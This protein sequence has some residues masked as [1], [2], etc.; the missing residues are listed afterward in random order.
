MTAL[1]QL[2]LALGKTVQGSDVADTFS[3][4]AVLQSAGIRVFTSA[5][6]DQVAPPI[7]CVVASSSYAEG[8]PEI[9]AARDRGITVISYAA[10]MGELFS[11]QKGIAVV[12]SHGKTTTTALLGHALIAAG[13]DPTVSV[14]FTIPQWNGNCRLGQSKW[15]V[16]EADEYQNKLRFFHPFG[17]VATNVDYDHVDFFPTRR[18]YQHVFHDFFA[19]IPPEGFFVYCAEDPFLTQVSLQ[20]KTRCYGYG[21]NQG[22]WQLRDSTTTGQ[23][24]SVV[25]NG[26]VVGQ[27]RLQIWGEK[28]LLNA[29][30]AFVAS[31]VLGADATAACRGLNEYRG[32]R[33]RMERVG[34]A[35]GALLLDDYAHHPAEIRVTL[36]AVRQHF[37][38]RRILALFQ[39]H[40]FS[41]TAAFLN[42]FAHALQSADAIA[43]LEIYPSAREPRG[44][45]SARPIVDQLIALGKAA[46]WTPTHAAAAAWLKK[47]ITAGDVVITLGAG[48]IW[49]L[50]QK[51]VTNV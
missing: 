48:D 8:H 25:H 35:S 38:H 17:V 20:L 15:F 26:K 21:L 36:N 16:A 47:H 50:A 49:Q 51:F 43:I 42:D 45:G 10:A 41:R 32:A 3:T 2:L 12:G 18:A 6:A 11:V 39:P 4:D 14:G 27:L 33:R 44:Q 1:A 22:E 40:T 29:L 13:L 28:N 31:Q 34:E 30:G 23:T 9:A 46:D 19:G 37:P 24:A 7:D 5:V